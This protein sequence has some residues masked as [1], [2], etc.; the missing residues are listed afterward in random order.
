M[1]G[2]AA[3]P[4]SKNFA[5][6]SKTPNIAGTQIPKPLPAPIQAATRTLLRRWARTGKKASR[7]FRLV[8][9]WGPRLAT[10]ALETR[11]P[12]GC[13]VS[14]DLNEFV[15][16]QVYFMGVFEPVESYLF[17]RL[18]RRGM[19]VI[20]AGANIGQYSLLASTAVGRSG[21]VHS[22]EP[23]PAICASLRRHVSLNRLSN[24]SVNQQALWHEESTVKLGLPPDDSY[25]AGSWTI[26]TSES[27]TAFVSAEAIRLDTYVSIH[28][29]SRIDLIKMDIQGA[30]PFALEG[31]RKLLAD[32]RPTLM[33]E[34]HRPSLVAL[35]SSPEALWALL[36]QFGY[37]AWRIRP[38]LRNSGP[39][40]NL[41]G[42]EFENFFFHVEDLPRAVTSGWRRET[43]KRWACSGWTRR[44]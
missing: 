3:R 18:L 37:R 28:N 35:G 39:M 34:V 15:Q 19:T 5:K 14:C 43:P 23:V 13:R 44:R 9:R 22:F 4:T 42:V 41:D 12:N 10:T 36:S 7:L 6:L 26:G 32:W 30:E 17:A 27:Q 8:E 33:M 1:A 11:L 29:L 40:P 20:D 2:R 16:R 21:S 25:N 38:S 24:V 31:A